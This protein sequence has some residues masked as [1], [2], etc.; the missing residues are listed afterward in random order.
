LKSAKVKYFFNITSIDDVWIIVLLLTYI[1]YSQ[2]LLEN[3]YSDKQIGK[4][5]RIYPGTSKLPQKIFDL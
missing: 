4:F 2:I 3:Y 1:G 5:G